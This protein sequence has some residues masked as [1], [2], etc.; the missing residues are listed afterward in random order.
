MNKNYAEDKYYR[1]AY[2]LG[3]AGKP[4]DADSVGTL[5]PKLVAGYNEGREKFLNALTMLNNYD[6]KKS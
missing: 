4:L 3:L 1:F 6:K 5:T 2:K